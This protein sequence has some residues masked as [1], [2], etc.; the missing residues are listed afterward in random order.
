MVDLNKSLRVPPHNIEAERALL[1]AVILKPETIHDVSAIV[2][3]E[4]F[5]ADKHREIFR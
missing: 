2:Y 3:P 4:S 1:G 5:Y